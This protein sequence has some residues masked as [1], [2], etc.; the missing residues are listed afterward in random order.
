M[1][2]TRGHGNPLSNLETSTREAVI[3]WSASMRAPPIPAS[4]GATALPQQEGAGAHTRD[5]PRA[6]VSGWNCASESHVHLLNTATLS[7]LGET[8]DLPNTW[9]QTQR[10]RQNKKREECVSNEKNKTKTSEKEL[11]ETEIRNLIKKKKS[12]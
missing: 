12:I 3:S 4:S 8:A 10:I 1:H 6:P 5:S 9:K 11:N 2:G 7:R